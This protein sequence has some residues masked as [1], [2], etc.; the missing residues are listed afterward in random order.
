MRASNARRKASTVSGSDRSIPAPQAWA[1]SRQNPVRA[2]SMPR[3]ASASAMAVSSSRSTPR[4]DPPPAE[5]SSTR[6]TDPGPPSTSART[7]ATP[8]ASRPTP[9]ATEVSR[10]EP[11][12]TF[13]NAASNARRRPQ[14][15]GQDLDG[16]LVG[17]RLRAGEV[18][19]VRG[20]DRDRADPPVG[21]PLAEGRRV[22]GRLRATA[23]GGGV[24]A[25]D[26]DGGRADRGRPL[27]GCREPGRHGQVGTESS[28]VWQHRRIVR[29]RHHAP[30]RRPARAAPSAPGS[31][32]RPGRRA[33]A[34]GHREGA[35]RPSSATTGSRPSRPTPRS[36]G[37]CSS[38]CATAASRRTARTRR[39][40]STSAWRCSTRTSRRCAGT[41]S[42]AA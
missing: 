41:W 28:T 34:A 20:V 9:S 13:R 38:T 39:R 4:V 36:A 16:A 17:H 32:A 27:D 12:W 1:V 10:C 19:Q 37:P 30:R 23:P 15:V 24:V 14:V 5:F 21:E 31:R 3:A 25:E 35:P 33:A 40:R 26:L 11:M 8:S 6:R 18:D 2:S 7:R 22:L 29:C 42:T